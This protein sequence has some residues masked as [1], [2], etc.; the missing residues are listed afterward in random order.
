MKKLSPGGSPYCS[1][2]MHCGVIGR[3]SQFKANIE[4]AKCIHTHNIK[5]STIQP[6]QMAYPVCCISLFLT[7]SCL[8]HDMMESLC[9]STEMVLQLVC[10]STLAVLS[11]ASLMIPT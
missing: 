5:Y 11:V 3:V 7:S 1:G 2:G 4:I 6:L 8:T 9:L 10:S